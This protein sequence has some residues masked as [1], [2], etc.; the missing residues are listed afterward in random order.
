MNLEYDDLLAIADTECELVLKINRSK[1]GSE[2][3]GMK[4]YINKTKNSDWR[5]SSEDTD[6]VT[7]LPCAVR[8]KVLA[9]IRYSVNID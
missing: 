8:R 5:E 4:N 9:I 2:K 3:K 7:K 6:R 1:D